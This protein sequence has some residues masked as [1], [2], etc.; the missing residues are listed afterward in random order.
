MVV[1]RLKRVL[2][3][4]SIVGLAASLATLNAR[5][6]SYFQT[7]EMHTDQYKKRANYVFY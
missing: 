6:D 4:G 7:W 3:A 5:I 1:L 2:P